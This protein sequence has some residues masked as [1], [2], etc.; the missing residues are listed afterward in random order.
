MSEYEK[1][2]GILE[3]LNNKISNMEKMLKTLVKG[4]EL[5]KIEN[6]VKGKKIDRKGPKYQLEE[7]V[8]DGFFKN[9]RSIP[10]ILEEL[11]KRNFH[12]KHGDLTRPLETLCHEKILR[13]D[14][15]KNK[16]NKTLWYYS[17]W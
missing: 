15:K 12:Y 16:N 5:T 14:K 8:R 6:L 11:D 3:K 10:D 2:I 9:Q 13:R 1:I 4:P 7:L 17:N